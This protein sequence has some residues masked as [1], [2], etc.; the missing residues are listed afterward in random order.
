[1]KRVMD[2]FDSYTFSL[3][4]TIILLATYTESSTPSCILP[5]R[6]ICTDANG[7]SVLSSFNLTLNAS[8][9][10][11][12][13]NWISSKFSAASV[14]FRLTPADY[15][16]TWHNCPVSQFIMNMNAGNVVTFSEGETTVFETGEIFFCDDTSGKG[17]RS[18]SY[19]NQSRYSVFVEVDSTFDSGPCIKQVTS[20]HR[21][22][23][24]N[25]IGIPLCLDS[26]SAGM[27]VLDQFAQQQSQIKT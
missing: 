17:H 26:V 19:Q 10:Y 11:G 2:C 15:D 3:G 27:M 12:G 13:D 25:H 9:G 16:T 4:I 6:K 8:S 7:N 5:I 18:Q 1:M 22:R 21:T 23:N 14:R 20:G 24:I